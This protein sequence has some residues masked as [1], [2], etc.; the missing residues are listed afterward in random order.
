M[1]SP[2]PFGTRALRY[3]VARF[4]FVYVVNSIRQF[5]SFPGC[6]QGSNYFKPTFSTYSRYPTDALALQDTS[7]PQVQI[8]FWTIL[9]PAFYLVLANFSNLEFSILIQ[10]SAISGQDILFAKKA[11]N[12]EAFAHCRSAMFQCFRNSNISSSVALVHFAEKKVLECLV[13]F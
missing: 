13:F 5:H 1:T 4:N 12:V 10:S 9:D 8:I 3:C 6:R 7:M 11:H 2:A